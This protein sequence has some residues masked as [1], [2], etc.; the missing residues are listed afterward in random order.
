MDG[1]EAVRPPAGGRKLLDWERRGGGGDQRIRAEQL[2][3]LAQERLLDR[4]V[5]NDG[6]DHESGLGELRDVGDHIHVLA[7]SLARTLGG[8]LA[9]RPE[10][11]PRM[12]VC[13]L[14]ET[15]RYRAASDDP[16][17]L[18]EG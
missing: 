12:L 5:L 2:A 13:D 15:P 9:P 11:D 17:P 6:L 8:V 14:R 3:E 18:S 1:G 10:D 4:D 16:Q 7:Q